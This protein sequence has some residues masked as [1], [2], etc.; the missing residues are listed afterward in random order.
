MCKLRH[1]FKNLLISFMMLIVAGLSAQEDKL[2]LAQQIYKTNPE[3][4]AVLIDSVIIHPLTKSDY[5]SWTVRAYVYY[6]LFK[7]NDQRNKLNS[8]LRDT[9]ISSIQISNSLGPDST[10]LLNNNRVLKNLALG[11]YKISKYL[12]EDSLN[13]EGSFK[14][15]MRYREFFSKVEPNY[16]TKEVEYNLAVG[17]VFSNIFNQDNNNTKAGEIAKVALLKVI[18]LQ[19][20]NSSANLNLGL[21][22][23]NQAANLSKSLEFGADFSTI[24]IV[25][26]NMVKLAKQSAGFVETVYKNEPENIKVI[27]A[28][29]YI[30]RM[31]NDMQKFEEFKG[32]LKERNFKFEDP[33]PEESKKENESPDSPNKDK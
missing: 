31:L 20:T 21:M 10:F 12:L 30:Y 4:A 22:Y 26:E 6:E 15:Y 2:N 16:D 7:K 19:P 9:I 1:I 11:Y 17:S 24:D 8:P 13:Y 18:E 3:E 23:Y 29:Y 33:K 25:Q 5:V 28:L 14:A 27:E 32:K